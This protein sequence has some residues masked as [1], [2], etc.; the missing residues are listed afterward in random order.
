MIEGL[1]SSHGLRQPWS[2]S[3]CGSAT[4]AGGSG[5][6]ATLDVQR[7]IAEKMYAAS[8]IGTYQWVMLQPRVQNYQYSN[9]LGK[10]TETYAKIRLKT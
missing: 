6:T 9:S 10:D 5:L 8:T 2:A 7:Y 4:V 3:A 1:L